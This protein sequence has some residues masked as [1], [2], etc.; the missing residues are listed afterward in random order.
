MDISVR[1]ESLEIREPFAFAVLFIEWP[2][3]DDHT[4]V[5][6]ARLRVPMN[7]RD[8]SPAEIQ[9]ELAPQVRACLQ[10]SGLQGLATGWPAQQPTDAQ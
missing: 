9:R 7:R 1:V 5:L 3:E 2:A 10:R 6:N 4:A 8:L